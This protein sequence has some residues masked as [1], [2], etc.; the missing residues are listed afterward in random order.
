[1]SRF[2]SAGGSDEP[3]A[4]D[5]AWLEAQKKIEATRQKKPDVGQQEGG[6]SLFD[7]LQANKAAKQDA[8]EEASRLRNQFRSLDEDEVEFLDS[9]LE[10]TR[11]KEAE[12]K[13]ETFEQLEAFRKQREEA[14]KVAKQEEIPEA[15]AAPETWAVGPRKRKK[16]RE[17]EGIGGIKI[18]RTSNAEL[19][20]EKAAQELKPVQDGGSQATK[21]AA[22]PQVGSTTQGRI[23]ASKRDAPPVAAAKPATSPRTAL[24]LAAYS[25]DEDE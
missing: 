24:G 5:E 7:T 6:K 15:V 19:K 25:S 8:F 4:Q 10:S 9:V 11:S 13:K 16:G 14:E 17:T 18:R 22:A 21:Q 23:A 3:T 2:V 1:M 12:V 20:D